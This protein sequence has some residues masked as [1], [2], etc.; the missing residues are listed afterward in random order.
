[1]IKG[2]LL[3]ID[4]TLLD[5]NEAH[6]KLWQHA[7]TTFG[8]NVTLDEIRTLMGMGG[9]RV[10][11]TLIPGLNTEEGKGAEISEYRK[12]CLVECVAPSLQPTPGARE[13][14]ASLKKRGMR[15]VIATSASSEELN[16]LLHQADIED[17]VSDYTTSSDVEQSKPA[18]DIVAVALRKSGLES[19]EVFM[20]GDT[21]YDIAAAKKLGVKTIAVR[22]G[23][24]SQE[25][26]KGANYIYNNPK[27][28]L[29]NLERII[30]AHA[31]DNQIHAY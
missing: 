23:G 4:G 9:D 11:P 19:H 24:F 25:Q 6:A 5:S 30:Y 10:L 27:D 12:K 14:L 8:Y 13:L 28:V 7:I 31:D 18:P 26:L 17:L 22:S 21:P 3:D 16:S 1:M 20:L 2:F 29:E 15:M